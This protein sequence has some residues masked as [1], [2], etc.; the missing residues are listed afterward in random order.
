MRTLKS[1]AVLALVLSC[2]WATAMTDISKLIPASSGTKIY[3]FEFVTDTSRVNGD[4][5][6][7]VGTRDAAY[8]C[9]RTACATLLEDLR[10]DVDAATQEIMSQRPAV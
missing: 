2:G 5:V 10:Y 7:I 8:A 3:Q 4:T 1:L 6:Y 9:Y